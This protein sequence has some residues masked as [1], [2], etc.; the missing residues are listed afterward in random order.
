MTK[1]PEL[2]SYA[3]F[4][5]IQMPPLGIENSFDLFGSI[6]PYSVDAPRDGA[7]DVGDPERISTVL[8]EIQNRIA[9]CG[10]KF[11]SIQKKLLRI[12]HSLLSL[13]PS[14]VPVMLFV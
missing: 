13:F 10:S 7:H 9:D 8:P 1:R 11:C 12:R 4:S 5:D 6:G 2:A 14:T 3:R